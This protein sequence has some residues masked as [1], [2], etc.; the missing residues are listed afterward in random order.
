MSFQTYSHLHSSDEHQ[1]FTLLDLAT[2]T[3]VHDLNSTRKRTRYVLRVGHIG[4]ARVNFSSLCS[5]VDHTHL[6]SLIVHQ[7]LQVARAV[8]V[9][10]TNTL[11]FNLVE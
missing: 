10:W 1:W 11:K 7:K 2:N 3:D 8:R 4:L 6:A 5:L 9:Q